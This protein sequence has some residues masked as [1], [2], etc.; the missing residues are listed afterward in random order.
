MALDLK[1]VSQHAQVYGAP[2]YK[3]TISAGTLAPGEYVFNAEDKTIGYESEEGIVYIRLRTARA[4]QGVDP[5]KDTFE[6]FVFEALRDA[7]GETADGR[8]WSVK[9]GST[10]LFAQ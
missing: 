10:K 7:S 2:L 5:E 1:I 4:E 8:A 9:A 6:V 3:Q